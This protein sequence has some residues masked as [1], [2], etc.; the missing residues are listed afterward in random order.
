MQESVPVL[1]KTSRPR[2]HEFEK[3]ALGDTNITILDYTQEAIT[4]F[5]QIR[6]FKD[7]WLNTTQ[8]KTTKPIITLNGE[9]VE[10]SSAGQHVNESESQDTSDTLEL[11]K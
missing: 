3:Y 5:R 10:M 9:V 7:G 4:S 6:T 11:Y 1:L 8:M 2:I